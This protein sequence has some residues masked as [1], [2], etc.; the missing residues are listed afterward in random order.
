M[1]DPTDRLEEAAS[2]E[3]YVSMMNELDRQ[4]ADAAN[5]ETDR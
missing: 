1:K 3:K 2:Y 5:E 4:F